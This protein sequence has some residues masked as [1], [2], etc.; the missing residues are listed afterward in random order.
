MNLQ[1]FYEIG[2]RHFYGK[3]EYDD[4]NINYIFCDDLYKTAL[5]NSPSERYTELLNNNSDSINKMNGMCIP[6]YF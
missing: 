4:V 2:I 1:E 6:F 5:E 3:A